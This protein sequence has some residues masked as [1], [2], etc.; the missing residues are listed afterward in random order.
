MR[1]ETLNPFVRAKRIRGILH[2][3]RRAEYI[4]EAASLWTVYGGGEGGGLL[5]S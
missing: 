1:V 4:Y 3:G 5:S 2:D